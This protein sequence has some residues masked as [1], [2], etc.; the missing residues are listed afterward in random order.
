[1]ANS[2]IL[3]VKNFSPSSYVEHVYFKDRMICI[4]IFSDIAT[5]E[6]LKSKPPTTIIYVWVACI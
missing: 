3:Y 4:L 6:S 2:L 1:M 5:K